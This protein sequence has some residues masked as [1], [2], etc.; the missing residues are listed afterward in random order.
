MLEIERANFKL[1]DAAK[2]KAWCAN[3]LKEYEQVK[4]KWQDCCDEIDHLCRKLYPNFPYSGTCYNCGAGTLPIAEI[5][6]VS[7][8]RCIVCGQDRMRQ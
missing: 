7:M 8:D 2:K 6:S 3:D 1:L 5:D 4:I